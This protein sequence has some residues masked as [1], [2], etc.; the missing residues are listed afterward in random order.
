MQRHPYSEAA[1]WKD[2]DLAYRLVANH[3]LGNVPAVVLR[4][5]L[6]PA[7]SSVAD[8][9]GFRRDA[10]ATGARQFR[11]LFGDASLEDWALIERHMRG[12]PFS[13]GDE[14]VRFGRWL[15]R[16]ADDQEPSFRRALRAR[17]LSACACAR[18]E[19]IDLEP[20]RAQIDFRLGQDP[21]LDGDS[22]ASP[23]GR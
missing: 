5:R 7:Q 4:Y 11:R 15:V 21:V 14:L 12:Q 23:I 19:E 22:L 18:I 20:L 17:W 1:I 2:L 8:R 13:N 16:L 3:R 9:E 6:H 10:I